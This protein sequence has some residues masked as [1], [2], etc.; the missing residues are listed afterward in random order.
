[1]ERQ[2]SSGKEVIWVAEKWL[3]MNPRQYLCLT[4]IYA[5]PTTLLALFKIPVVSIITHLSL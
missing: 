5:L 1:M 3:Q 2:D 4:P